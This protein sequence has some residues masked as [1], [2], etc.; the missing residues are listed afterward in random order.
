MNNKEINQVAE[1]FINLGASEEQAMTMAGQLIKRS[2]Q[3]AKENN[4]SQVTE[5]Q[6]LLETAV[7]GAQGILKPTKKAD[8]E[9]KK[10]RNP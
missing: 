2:A 4:S 1:I 8:S 7:Y 3:L 5:L 9:Q 6:S 10:P